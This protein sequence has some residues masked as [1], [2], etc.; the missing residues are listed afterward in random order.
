MRLK[1]S[2]DAASLSLLSEKRSF[3]ISNLRTMPNFCA[4]RS[5]RT[6][7]ADLNFSSD[8]VKGQLRMRKVGSWNGNFDWPVQRLKAAGS[9]GGVWF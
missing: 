3:P 8:G 9:K 5:S 7:L 6:R 1:R 4:P 2:H